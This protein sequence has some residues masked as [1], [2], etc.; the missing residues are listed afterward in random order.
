MPLRATLVTTMLA[1]LAA[2]PAHAGPPT[3]VLGPF[4]WDASAR[5]WG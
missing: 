1:A 5:A 4:A 3:E 2:A